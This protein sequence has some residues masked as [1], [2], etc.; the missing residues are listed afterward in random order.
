MSDYKC[1]TLNN[2]RYNYQPRNHVNEATM[3]IFPSLISQNKDELQSQIRLLGPHCAGFHIDIMD[4][5]F[6][7]Q[8]M[9]SVDLTNEIGRMT[10]K[11]LWIHIMA[12]DPLS[13][14]KN[15]KPRKGDII[16]FHLSAH[17]NYQDIIEVIKKK[18]ALPSLALN[19]TIPISLLNTSLHTLDHVTIMSV[20]PGKSGQ[21]FIPKT[22][23]KLE[24]LNAFKAAHE[25][26][27]TIS[28]DGGVNKKNIT[29]LAALGVN[30]VAVSSAILNADNPLKAL[31]ELSE[32]VAD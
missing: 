1:L 15:L 30:Q 9:G 14:I 2:P 16:S 17:Y 23:H 28:V 31:Q 11:Q 24:R 12:K 25:C 5:I 21:S 7:H 26:T 4:G 6:V 27:L 29:R 20:E 18:N 10:Q 8:K 22:L 32:M 3:Q 13:I 19:P